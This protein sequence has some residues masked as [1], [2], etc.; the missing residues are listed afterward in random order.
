MGIMYIVPDVTVCASLQ[1]INNYQRYRA[2][3]DRLDIDHRSLEVD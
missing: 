3:G 1:I 2:L